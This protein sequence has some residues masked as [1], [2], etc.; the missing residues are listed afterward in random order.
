[1]MTIHKTYSITYPTLQNVSKSL[2]R[3]EKISGPKR[4]NIGSK[5]AGLSDLKHQKCELM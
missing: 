2:V 1:M 5:I 3:S 4:S